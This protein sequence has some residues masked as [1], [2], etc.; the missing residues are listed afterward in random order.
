VTRPHRTP[1]CCSRG[2]RGQAP[3][4]RT[5]PVGA[6]HPPEGGDGEPTSG[7]NAPRGDARSASSRPE[8]CG[9]TR[10]LTPQAWAE[11]AK[12]HVPSRARRTTPMATVVVGAAA[13]TASALTPAASASTPPWRAALT[14]SPMPVL[15][16]GDR[17]WAVKALLRRLGA[18]PTGFFDRRLP[19]VTFRRRGRLPES[20]G[21]ARQGVGRP[22]H[23]GR[24]AQTPRCRAAARGCRARGAC[25]SS[26]P[27]P[28]W[29]GRRG[30]GPGPAPAVA[31]IR[32][33]T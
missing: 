13:W 1:R 11:P 8:L 12:N 20:P 16:R 21:S 33:S 28:N 14:T 6:R 5:P 24:T 3:N 4:R 25:R 18:S 22:V 31:L 26:L 2:K 30:L 9:R 17:G 23:V 19:P 15:E 27:R 7:A 29:R 10:Q 32:A